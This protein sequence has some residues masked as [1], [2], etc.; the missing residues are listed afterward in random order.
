MR[1]LLGDIGGTYARFALAGEV[2]LGAIWS[3]EVAAC[4]DVMQ[5]IDQFLATQPP[6]TRIDGAFLAAAGPVEGGRCKLTNAAWTIDEELIAKTFGFRWVRMVNDLEAV[7]AGLSD[8][9]ESQ[10]RLIGPEGGLP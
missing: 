2:A 8:L 1:V 10:T 5:A 4:A 3:I 9:P 6:G 7:A